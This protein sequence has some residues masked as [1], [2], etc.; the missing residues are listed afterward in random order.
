MNDLTN[1]VLSKISHNIA[2][3]ILK[4][5][6]NS[7][8]N[9]IFD[10]HG[11]YNEAFDKCVSIA[12][13]ENVILINCKCSDETKWQSQLSKRKGYLQPSQVNNFEIIKKSRENKEEIKSKYQINIDTINDL[14]SNAKKIINYLKEIK[15]LQ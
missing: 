10:S 8:L 6:I 15:K 14:D 3:N 11:Y 9:I 12:G 1:S 13:I 5:N 7:N 2:K 4:S